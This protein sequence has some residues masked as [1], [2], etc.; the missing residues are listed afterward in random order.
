MKINMKV[1]IE[2]VPVSQEKWYSKVRELKISTVLNEDCSELK[3]WIGL[4]FVSS[5]TLWTR[6]VYILNHTKSIMTIYG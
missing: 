4:H 5:D 6:D 2:K 1:N 3:E